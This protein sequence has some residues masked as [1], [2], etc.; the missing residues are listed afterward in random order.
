MCECFPIFVLCNVV[1]YTTI[2]VVYLS[3]LI[4]SFQ[5]KYRIS[6]IWHEHMTFNLIADGGPLS[7]QA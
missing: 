5:H 1:Y 2:E 3:F 7:G 4:F 6:S